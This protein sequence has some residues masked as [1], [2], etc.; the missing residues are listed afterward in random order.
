MA[1]RFVGTAAMG[2]ISPTKLMAVFAA[3]N[4]VLTL[5]AALAGGEPGLVALAATSFFMSIMFPTIFATT[6]KGLGPLTKTGSSF[7][8]MAIIGGAVFTALMGAISD[9]SAI[10][11]A[12]LVPSACFAVVAAYGLSAARAAAAMDSTNAQEAPLA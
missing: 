12:I 8:V 10:N 6:I 7:L 1:G 9:L 11:Y 4:A 3:I 2:K 5:F